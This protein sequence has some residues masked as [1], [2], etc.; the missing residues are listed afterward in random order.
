MRIDTKQLEQIVNCV[1]SENSDLFSENKIQGLETINESK[2]NISK[3]IRITVEKIEGTCTTTH[4]VGEQFIIRN[5]KT[6]EGICLTAFSGLLPYINA[7]L[8]DASFQWES[9]KGQICLGCPDP[10]NRVI[11]SIELID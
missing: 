9:Q 7:L 2:V 10:Q 1:K 8:Y 4:R 11:F 3:R 5:G 6:P